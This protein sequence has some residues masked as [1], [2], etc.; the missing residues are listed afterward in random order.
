MQCKSISQ[1]KCLLFFL[2]NSRCNFRGLQRKQ[3]EKKEKENY[4]PF[5]QTKEEKEKFR[6]LL[7]WLPLALASLFF[8]AFGIF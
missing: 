3:S 6:S 2:T 8:H 7:K 5:Y 1:R 4:F